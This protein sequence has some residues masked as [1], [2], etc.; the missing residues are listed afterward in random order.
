M[1]SWAGATKSRRRDRACRRRGRPCWRSI[2]KSARRFQDDVAP[3]GCGPEAVDALGLEPAVGLDF[4]EHLFGV[5]EQLACDRAVGWAVE[6]GGE[7]AFQFSQ[8][9]EDRSVDVLTEL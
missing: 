1:W 3:V 9:E 7:L 8:G 5:A 4:V 6:D 2:G